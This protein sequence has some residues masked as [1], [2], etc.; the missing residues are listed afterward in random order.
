MEALGPA[1]GIMSQA[2]ASLRRTQL[3]AKLL[4]N[5]DDKARFFIDWWRRMHSKRRPLIAVAL[6]FV[7]WAESGAGSQRFVWE[8]CRWPSGDSSRWMFVCWMV[9]GIGMWTRSF[10]SKRAALTYFRQAPATVLSRSPEVRSTEAP[11]RAAS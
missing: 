11:S 4:S 2:V 6:K 10:S 9:D 5:P 7:E 3:P 8:V 1:G